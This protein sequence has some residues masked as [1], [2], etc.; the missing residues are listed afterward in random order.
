MTI[1]ADL[2]ANTLNLK[3]PLASIQDACSSGMTYVD[4]ENSTNRDIE[5]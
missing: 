4:D 2:C 5:C 3:I 1:R